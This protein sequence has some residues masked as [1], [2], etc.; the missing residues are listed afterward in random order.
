VSEAVNAQARIAP[1]PDEE[2]RETS[3]R[4]AGTVISEDGTPIGYWRAGE[5]PPLVLVHGTS[6]DHTRWD[7]VLPALEEH[8]TVYTIDR[9]GQ[10]GSGDAADY[11]LEREVEDVLAVVG[12]IGAPV[13]LLGHS[14]G[15]ICSLEASRR[16]ARMRRLVLYEPPLSTS[17]VTFPA[18]AID[19]V[20]ALIEEGD[21]EEAVAIFLR[22]V[23]GMPSHA[24]DQLRLDTAAWQRRVVAAHTLPREARAAESYVLD[25]ARFQEFGTQTLLLL[26]A[27]SP[28]FFKAATEAV[29]EALPNSR[30]VVM[31]RQGHVAMH[32][33]PELFT[34][35]AVQFLV[36][37]Q[38]W[39]TTQSAGHVASRATR[40]RKPAAPRCS[41][42][43]RVALCECA[44]HRST[45]E[46]GR[47]EISAVTTD[48]KGIVLLL[49]ESETI[50]LS[51]NRISFV[52]RK[53][54]SAYSLLEWVAAPGVPGTPLHIHRATDEAFYVLEGTFGFQV[55]EETVE[56][57]AG[58]FVF[59][60]KGIEHAYWNLGPSPA[61]MLI[62]ISPPGFERYFEELAE[63]L[64][65]VGD[66]E[67]AVM[68]LRRTLS[69]KHDIEVVGPP[70][71]VAD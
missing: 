35:L 2:N 43:C 64:A 1:S 65:S 59:A 58:A 21:Q 14:Y 67:E 6:A 63:G 3:A 55:G 39:S 8:F 22:E 44:G 26:G 23:A 66:S 29:D 11:S 41:L 12:S 17:L 10:G 15:A 69:A 19:C 54:D 30:I 7:P 70:R 48:G 46:G 50:S 24:V 71:R 53:P 16:S 18:E 38:D 57:P 33:A 27:E 62:T 20:E 36:P 45:R 25:P 49:G 37:G 5:G 61:K 51:G 31:P 32:T 40:T 34:S 13:S 47:K 68:D 42:I 28:P 52:H 56:A 9:R 4:Q 60:P